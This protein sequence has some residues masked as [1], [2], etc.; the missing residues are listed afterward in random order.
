VHLTRYT[1]INHLIADLSGRIQR[2]LD[3]NLAGLYL[4]GSLVTGD[5]DPGVSD[6]DLLATTLSD[7]SRAEAEAL[8]DMHRDFALANPDWDDRVEVVYIST[9]ALRTFRHRRSPIAVIS[10]G[11]PFHV[12]DAGT[13]WLQSWYAVREDSVQLCGPPAT[14]IIGPITSEEFAQCIRDYTTELGERVKTLQSRKAQAYEIL[15]MCRALCLVRTGKRVS[16]KQ[17]ALWAQRELPEWAG[18]IRA[19]VDWRLS[20]REKDADHPATHAE[21][22]RFVHLVRDQVLAARPEP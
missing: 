7:L 19:A 15:T 9:D 2:T 12:F 8:R 10:P 17:A 5:F 18:L 21:T 11:E 14:A 16:K 1:D 22:I 13:E 3:G 6:M 20:W 4:Y